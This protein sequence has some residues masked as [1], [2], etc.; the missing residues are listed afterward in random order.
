M[1]LDWLDRAVTTSAYLWRLERPDGIA[2][3]FT[4]HDRDL[5]VDAFRYRAAP[6]MVPSTIALSDS[7]DIDNVEISGVMT[8]A[9]IAESDLDAGRW[10]G[11]LLYISLVDW[12]QPEAEPLPLICGEFGEIVR[13]G[14]SFTVEMLGATSFLDEPVAPLT[15]PTCRAEFGDRLCKLSLHRHQREGRIITVSADGIGVDGLNDTAADFAFGSLRFLD[16]PN[17]GLSYAIVDGEA[18][19]VRLADRPAQPV[20]PGTR[21]LL[22]E[23]CNKNFATCRDRF[24][25]SINF[26]GEPYLPGNDLL[27]RYPGA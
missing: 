26:R 5:F 21:V 20:V 3:G 17:C 22:T 4:S 10:D 7:L 2:L 23:G 18:A 14:D 24:A 13:S 9:A 6:G 8:S 19:V 11:A 12:E 15:S 27:T 16:G 25:N 1:S